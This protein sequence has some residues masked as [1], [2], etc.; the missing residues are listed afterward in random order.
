M[1]RAIRS[2]EAHFDVSDF[3]NFQKS[4]HPQ[5]TY[6][7]CLKKIHT[8]TWFCFSREQQDKKMKR[9]HQG[10]KVHPSPRVMIYLQWIL[11]VFLFILLSSVLEKYSVFYFF[12]HIFL[13][14]ILPGNTS[15]SSCKAWVLFIGEVP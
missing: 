6:L 1:K 7:Y 11:L 15:C 4:I 8:E 5:K 2:C 9:K 10:K 3:I 14:N 13:I 12:L